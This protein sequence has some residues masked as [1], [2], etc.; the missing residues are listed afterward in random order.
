MTLHLSDLRQYRSGPFWAEYQAERRRAGIVEDP[1]YVPEWFLYRTVMRRFAAAR[2]AIE[3][4]GPKA[5]TGFRGDL[6][7]LANLRVALVAL[8]RFM[9]D[10]ANDL[11]QREL[12]TA[13]MLG[14]AEVEEER[15]RRQCAAQDFAERT[16]GQPYRFCGDPAGFDGAA[17]ADRAVEIAAERGIELKRRP[18]R[19]ALCKALELPEDTDDAGLIAAAAVAHQAAKL[20][21]QRARE[22]S[23]GH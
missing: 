19:E 2:G 5:V 23:D 1:D 16:A 17:I 9:R 7:P 22:A 14:A 10:G 15:E 13:A 20:A 6:A 12:L 21:E 8:E 4:L 18:L 3:Q 11:G